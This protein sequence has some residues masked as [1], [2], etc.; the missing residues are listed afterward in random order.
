MMMKNYQAYTGENRRKTNTLRKQESGKRKEMRKKKMQVK[1]DRLKETQF[2]PGGN[3]PR[4]ETKKRECWKFLD[5]RLNS[6]NDSR[7]L[8]QLSLVWTHGGF[9]VYL[10]LLVFTLTS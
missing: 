9:F 1:E 2:V 6:E 4:V 7:F 5:W 10:L 3:I 8:A